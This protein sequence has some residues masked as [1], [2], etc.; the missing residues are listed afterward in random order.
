MTDQ[1]ALRQ[2]FKKPFD[3]ASLPSTNLE[4]RSKADIEKALK[5]ATNGA[6]RHGQAHEIIALVN[7]ANVKTLFHGR[8]LFDTLA[9]FI[10]E[11]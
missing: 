11:A 3:H 10:A 8:R 9:C 6:Y 2:F 4:S 7:L 1:D 5:K